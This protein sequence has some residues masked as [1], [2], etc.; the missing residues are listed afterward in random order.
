MSTVG[1]TEVDNLTP[2]AK[3]T[4]EEGLTSLLPHE[5]SADEIYTNLW[6]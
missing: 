4:V 2:T 1:P 5:A 3:P 6:T